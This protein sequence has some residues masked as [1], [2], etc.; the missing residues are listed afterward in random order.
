MLQPTG[1]A[2]RSNALLH[3]DL[4]RGVSPI[5]QSERG[6]LTV[7]AAP[8]FSVSDVAMALEGPAYDRAGNL[9]FVDIYGGRVLRLSRDNELSTV[10][11]DLTLRPAGIAIHRD[12]TIFVA[13]V[14]DFEA[15]RVVAF[16]PDGSN[17]RDIVP[18]SAGFVPD[19]LTFDSHG[20]FYF[21]DFR[22]SPGQPSGGVYYV[23]SD[24]K[25]ITP[26]LQNMAA[27][28]GVTLSP[29]GSVLWSTEFGAGRLHRVELKSPTTYSHFG[30]TVP[31]H[32]SG[33]APDSM[34][35]DADGNVYV[36]MYTQGRIMAFSPNGVPIGQILMPGRDDNHFL[37][38]TSLAFIPGSTEV[39]IVA[40]DEV[41]KG[42]AMIFR[43]QA[44][45]RGATLFSH[46]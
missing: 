39:R 44:F 32:F 23:A 18:A 11:T 4:T 36:A 42:R 30:W 21:T 17:A 13:G 8:Y 26:V 9:L 10:Y 7:T 20:G 28:N 33:R 43:A 34:R 3:N 37:K 22:G 46:Q 1:V 19:D 2:D 31:Y 38:T 45:A 12:G 29:N 35:T 27:S 40:Q 24:M 6:L 25:T 15:G 5:P 14:G 41:G 16:D